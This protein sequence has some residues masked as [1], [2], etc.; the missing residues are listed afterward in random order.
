MGWS[1]DFRTKKRAGKRALR[2][3][4]EGLRHTWSCRKIAWVRNGCL[5][6]AVRW[7]DN[8]TIAR[9]KWGVG[10]NKALRTSAR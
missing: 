8:G 2:E 7:N 3:C 5:A 4:K 6:L 9:Y 1:Y 10:R